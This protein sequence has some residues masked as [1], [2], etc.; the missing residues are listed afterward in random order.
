MNARS[1][2]TGGNCQLRYLR[3][4]VVLPRVSL[5]LDDAYRTF[6]TVLQHLDHT[7]SSCAAWFA[8][9]WL[10]QHSSCIY[11]NSARE[12]FYTPSFA[13]THPKSRP[14]PLS[15]SVTLV[16]KLRLYIE[17]TFWRSSLT[18][19]RT[20]TFLALTSV[21][22]GDNISSAIPVSGRIWSLSVLHENVSRNVWLVLAMWFLLF[23]C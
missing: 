11:D 16:P 15:K 10:R 18:S 4:C 5:A 13:S 12:S 22:S 3:D 21:D 7:K 1:R 23:L 2:T 19:A 14:S 6:T 17:T 9:L 20:T 8:N